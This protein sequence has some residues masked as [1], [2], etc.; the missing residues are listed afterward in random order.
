[1]TAYNIVRFRVKPDREQDFLDAH[2]R[3]ALQTMAGMRR[4]A[5]VKTGERAYC[6]VG[7]WDGFGN[8]AAARPAM[9]GMLDQFRDALEDLGGGLGITDPVSGEVA[10][11]MTPP[12]KPRRKAKA[13]AKAKA[14]PKA[15]AKKP[16]KKKAAHKPAAKKKPAKK[17][18]GRR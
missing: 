9:I 5:L 13:K 4:A 18:G 16:A 1:M 3:A 6:F 11:D 10:V 15:K 8:I 17:R 12:A 7:E 2:R 14:K